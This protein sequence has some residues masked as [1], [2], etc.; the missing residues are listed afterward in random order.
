MGKKIITCASFGG[1]G[2]S[3]ITD[4]LKEFNKTVSLGSYEFSIAHEIDGIS[5][6]E[7]FLVNDNHRLK[8]DEAIFRFKKLLKIVSK[9]YSEFISNF[10][11][12]SEKY[13]D[14]LIEIS[15]EG[16][17]HRHMNR[18]SSMSRF[19]LF[20]LPAKVQRN[21]YKYFLKKSGYEYIPYYKRSTMYYS[22]PDN[23]YELTKEY[24][25]DILNNLKD[26]SSKKAEYIVMDQ[27]VPP[28]N[29]D[30]YLNYF[31][32]IKIICV[33]RDPRDLYT[34]NKKYWKEGWIPS[35]DV[36]VFIQWFKS[37]RKNVESNDSDFVLRIKFEDLIYNYDEAINTIYKFT[38][39][40]SEEHKDKFKYFNPEISI[41]NTQVWKK[42]SDLENDIKLI[43]DQ[44]MEFC[45]KFS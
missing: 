37:L 20:S 13:L 31:E 12:I 40:N 3:A 35:E 32:D 42:H 15:W 10:D 22:N 25:N 30:R 2:S 41:K 24:F 36:N 18:Y 6:L 11:E 23:F 43:E 39:L 9:Q 16:Y 38:S 1:T 7:H 17:W 14:G 5:D 19:L 21:I 4:L 27:L 29:T 28:T 33:D 45:Y 44:L 8:V 34:L 26:E